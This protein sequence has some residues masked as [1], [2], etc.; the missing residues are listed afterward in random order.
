M[1][2]QSH[3]HQSKVGW[4]GVLLTCGDRSGQ[5]LITSRVG[6]SAEAEIVTRETDLLGRHS[7]WGEIDYLVVDEAQFLTER[8]V[9]DLA[10]LV[11]S[12]NVDVICVGLTTDFRSLMFEGSKRLLEMSDVVQGLQ[13]QGRC[14]CSKIATHN[15]R[16][17]G[18]GEV[19]REGEV[20]EIGDTGS[21][22]AS[23]YELL[24]REHYMA[25]VSE[26]RAKNS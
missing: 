20:L 15:A 5:A 8:Q 13:V 14:W 10:R 7:E 1:A 25:G 22:G 18:E 3:Y 21:G 19:L 6:M 9:E 26:E 17:S 4:K 24:C 2:L 12:E 23:H 11:D 16:V